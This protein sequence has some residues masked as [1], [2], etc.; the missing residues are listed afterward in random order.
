MWK[1]EDDWFW[2]GNIQERLAIYFRNLGY[3]VASANTLAKSQGVDIKAKR[4]NQE[5]VIEVKGFPSD[6]YADGEKRGQKKKTQPSLQAHHWF[7]DVI[8][9]AIRRKR[10]YPNSIIA[11]GL[12]ECQRYQNLTDEIKWALDKLDIHI[13]IVKSSGEVYKK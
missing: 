6:K 4:E 13:F 8:F 10:Q 11:I 1:K 2:E 3:E 12:P 7:S 5:V 9:S